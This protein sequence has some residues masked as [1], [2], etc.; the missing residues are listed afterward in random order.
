MAIDFPATPTNGQ[1]FTSGTT[2][3]EYNSTQQ[4]WIAVVDPAWLKSGTDVYYTGGDVGIGTTNP[5][6]RLDIQNAGTFTGLNVQNTTTT[7]VTS[8]FVQN[9]ANNLTI[10]VSPTASFIQYVNGPLTLSAGG[11]DLFTFST[12][13]SLGIGITPSNSAHLQIA[14]G[15]TTEVPLEFTSGTLSTTPNDGSFE[16]DGTAFYGT[17]VASNRGVFTTQHFVARTGTKTMTSNTNLQSLFGGGTG[18]L[19]NG[20]LTVAAATSYYFECSMNLSTMSGTSGNLGFSIV[21]A[22]TATFTSA[23]W[24]AFG[25]DATTQTTAAAIGGI[26]NATQA[27]TGNIVTA[28]TG[29]AVSVFVK[30]IFRINAGGTI[31]PSVQLT[32]AN[33]AVI[34]TNTWFRCYPVGSNTIISVG[35]WS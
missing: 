28:G 1:Q 11:S 33:A 5:A 32:T 13:G 4:Q 35:N 15:N 16:Y 18:G 19:T 9:T 2:V 8:L 34:G 14:A 25:L 31:I 23:A 3:Y 12:A 22:G 29:T 21:G 6:Y 10:G 27:A 7:G 17:P 20:A 30:G 26:F 24:H